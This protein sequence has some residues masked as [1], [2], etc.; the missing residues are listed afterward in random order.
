VAG[1][2]A[3]W[4]AGGRA[5]EEG[6]RGGKKRLDQLALGAAERRAEEE[7]SKGTDGEAGGHERDAAE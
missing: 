4:A 3:A 2:G 6:R 5:G 7:R 1:I